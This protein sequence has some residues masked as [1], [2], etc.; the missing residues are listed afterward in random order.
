MAYEYALTGDQQVTDVQSTLT[1]QP[2]Q[3][4]ANWGQSYYPATRGG[5]PFQATL[6]AWDPRP[7]LQHPLVQLALVAA[8]A[9]LLW[10]LLKG[11]KV[12]R[13]PGNTR[14]AVEQ[15]GGVHSGGRNRIATIGRWADGTYY[16]RLLRKK[17]RRTGRYASRADAQAAL[18][19][20]GYAE[21]EARENAQGKVCKV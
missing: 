13:N 20:R 11:G 17:A 15:A 7:L 19:A 21:L 18:C 12:R 5:S 2:P 4:G 9:W 14:T 10:K 8:G 6:G 3:H 1:V 16:Y